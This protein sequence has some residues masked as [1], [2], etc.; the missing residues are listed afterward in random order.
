LEQL[1]NLSGIS[2]SRNRIADVSPLAGLRAPSFVFL[3]NN[4][5]KDLSPLT[6]WLTNDLAGPKRF[7]PFVNFYVKGN[8]LSA[9]SKRLVADLKQQGVRF[10]P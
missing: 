4:R 9:K 10:N 8:K 3:E 1:R 5:I 2:L 7:A 6:A